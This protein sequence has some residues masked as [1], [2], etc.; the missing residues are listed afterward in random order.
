MRL[1]QALLYSLAFH[2]LALLGYAATSKPPHEKP[3]VRQ[4]LPLRITLT[5]LP[6]APSEAD[7]Q[8]STENTRQLSDAT[9]PSGATDR[10]NGI[11]ED[12][13]PISQLD[14]PPQILSVPD[15]DQIKLGPLGHGKATIRLWVSASGRV[16][17]LKVEATTLPEEAMGYLTRNKEQFRLEPG[18]KNLGPAKSV[19]RFQIEITR[20]PTLELQSQDHRPN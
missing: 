4:Q 11:A 18:R 3:V 2:A 17:R 19:I 6:T 14:T 12:Y 20:D 7:K 9:P 10:R 8:V 16:D 1:H 5:H 15:L 13:L